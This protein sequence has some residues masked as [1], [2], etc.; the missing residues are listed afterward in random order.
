MTYSIKLSDLAVKQL[1]KFDGHIRDRIISA[2]RRCEIRPYAH[3]KKLVGNP[4][5]RLRVGDYR[6]IMDIRENELL[7]F[8]IE[9]GHRRKI[10]K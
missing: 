2:L 7:I 4:Y 8:V 5:F 6:V 3:V 9:V 10:Y 1:D